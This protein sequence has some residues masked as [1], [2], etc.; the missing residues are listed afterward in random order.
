MLAAQWPRSLQAA[1]P[2]QHHERDEQ[3]DEDDQA[4]EHGR[5]P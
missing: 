5:L 4:D 2:A 1:L 3:G